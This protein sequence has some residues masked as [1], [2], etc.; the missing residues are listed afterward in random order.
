MSRINL[1]PWREGVRAAQKKQF[2]VIL[3]V[4]SLLTVS[5]MLAANMW[6]NQQ[7]ARQQQRNRFLQNETAKLDLVLGEIRNIREQ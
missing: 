6:V 2:M 1:L 4:A 7:T 5:V 3:A